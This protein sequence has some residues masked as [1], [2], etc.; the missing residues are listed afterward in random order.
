MM[1]SDSAGIVSV[2]AEFDF[3]ALST[4]TGLT[5]DLQV[6]DDSG[7]F[8]TGTMTFNFENKNE[9]PTITIGT[10]AISANEGPVSLIHACSL[11]VS[12]YI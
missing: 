7:D 1:F 6:T 2:K 3:E 4:T 12:S 9:G 11:G 10:P 8:G 5:M